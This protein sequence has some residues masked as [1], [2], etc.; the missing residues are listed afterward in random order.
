MAKKKPPSQA[1]KGLSIEQGCN[2]TRHPPP[3]PC[4]E[5]IINYSSDRP[6]GCGAGNSLD[7]VF[8]GWTLLPP[9]CPLERERVRKPHVSIICKP[10]RLT[11]ERHWCVF[12]RMDWI[13]RPHMGRQW[14]MDASLSLIMVA[15]LWPSVPWLMSGTLPR[16]F[17]LQLQC[18]KH[19]L[20]LNIKHHY[21]V[22]E[23]QCYNDL[24]P[25]LLLFYWLSPFSPA[26]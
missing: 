21:A 6:L 16:L 3:T 20:C 22:N 7:L 1:G 4:N 25:H 9:S 24:F 14:P 17:L 15:F 10:S 12:W 13:G 5:N 23:K 19:R 18:P 11:S 26:Y 8:V 2:P